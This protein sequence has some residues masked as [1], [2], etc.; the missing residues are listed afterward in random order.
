MFPPGPKSKLPLPGLALRRD[1]LGYLSSL[2]ERYGDI[3]HF[4]V[5][6]QNFYLLNHPDHIR[7]VLV[8]NHN[9][10]AKRSFLQRAKRMLGEGLLTSE[11]EHYRR[12]RQVIQP[13]FHRQRIPKHARIIVGSAEEFIARWKDDETRDVLADMRS[14]SLA[15]TYGTLFGGDVEWGG[16]GIREQLTTAIQG[17]YLFGGSHNWKTLIGRKLGLI[18]PNRFQHACEKL[19]AA[20]YRLISERRERGIE[21]GDILSTLMSG[22]DEAET[23]PDKEVR[24]E[25]VTLIEAGHITLASVLTWVWFLLAVNSTAEEKLHAEVDEVLGGRAPVFEDLPKLPYTNMVLLEAMR[26]YSPVW[27]MTRRALHDY[28]VGGYVLPA[29][30]IVL[31]SQHV[32]HHDKR[33]YAQPDRFDPERWSLK[34]SES[35]P[36]F[37][38]FPF[39]GGPRRCI[40]EG[41]SMLEGVLL[42]ATMAS[43]WRLRSLTGS[44]PKAIAQVSVVV[45]RIALMKLERR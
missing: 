9:N 24:D 38:Y 25:V 23:L 39:G 31:I 2:A 8:T 40:G 11:G 43:K 44:L 37:S 32:M 6:A 15:A 41:L 35:R 36:Q 42:L 12:H 45:P 10:F 3:V 20:I 4:R 30:S 28:E 5:G 18:D 22:R 19:D 1:P 27:V 34:T 33:Y 14:L 7:D 16:C 17:L 21:K 13:E 29:G 26:L